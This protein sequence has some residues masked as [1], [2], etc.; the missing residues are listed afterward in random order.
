MSGFVGE[1]GGELGLTIGQGQEAARCVDI[2]AGKCEGVYDW[3][4]EDEEF[5]IYVW[6]FRVFGYSIA[7]LGDVLGDGC[8]VVNAELR[9]D[10]LVFFC[11]DLHFLLW[12]H[13]GGELFFA[14]GRV[15]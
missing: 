2:A 7:D 5:V 3:A 11:A 9:D 4:V 10:F 8:V 1:D 15:C 12:G 14:G 6:A 13:E